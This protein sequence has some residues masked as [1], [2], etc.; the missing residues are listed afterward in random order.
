MAE[1]QEGAAVEAAAASAVAAEVLAAPEAVALAE[2]TVP[3]SQYEAELAKLRAERDDSRKQVSGVQKAESRARAELEQLKQ[4]SIQAAIAQLPEDQREVVQLRIR[5]RA[6]QMQAE[7]LLADK[8]AYHFAEKHGVP[9]AELQ[10]LLTPEAVLRGE[11]TPELL[12]AKAQM[13]KAAKEQPNFEMTQKKLAEMEKELE[14]LKAAKAEPKVDS[15]LSVGSGGYDA[16]KFRGTG[17]VAG[18]LRAQRQAGL[19]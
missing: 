11:V 8:A 9:V 7:L 16:A 5:E 18:A 1:N 17:D 6:L 2:E 14:L 12:E 10:G 15:G 13:L 3:K 4:Q 19:R